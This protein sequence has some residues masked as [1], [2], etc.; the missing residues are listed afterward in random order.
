MS[1]FKW[2]TPAANCWVLGSKAGDHTGQFYWRITKDP[3]FSGFSIQ[4]SSF[5]LRCIVPSFGAKAITTF[6][7]AKALCEEHEA[8]IDEKGRIK[9]DK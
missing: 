7:E 1:E 3:R 4:Q 6:E 5:E 2:Q 8:L 9:R